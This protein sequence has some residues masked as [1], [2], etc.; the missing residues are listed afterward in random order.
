M[1]NNEEDQ[2]VFQS[3]EKI[4]MALEAEHTPTLESLMTQLYNELS[5]LTI[6][7]IT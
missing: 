7:N 3:F 4:K 6:Y 5:P 1:D 2:D